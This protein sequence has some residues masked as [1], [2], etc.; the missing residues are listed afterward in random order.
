MKRLQLDF[1]PYRPRQRRLAGTLAALL[2]GALIVGSLLQYRA[3]SARIA[4]HEAATQAAKPLLSISAQPSE[5]QQR[6][7]TL[8]LAAQRVLNLPWEPLLA[9]LEQAQGGKVQLLALQPIP[10]RGELVLSGEAENFKALMDYLQ[11]LRALPVFAEVTLVNQRQ[12]ADDGQH[13]LAFTLAAE[14]KAGSP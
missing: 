5:A 14:W 4:Q 2:A 3:I 7:L 9:A 8:A 6:E 10:L 11:Q 13:R 12:L 1:S